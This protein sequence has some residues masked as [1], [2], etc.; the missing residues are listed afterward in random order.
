M[1]GL[2]DTQQIKADLEEKGYAI[3]SDVLNTQEITDYINDYRKWRR[4]NKLLRFHMKKDPHGIHKFHQIGHQR[5]VWKVRLNKNVQAVFKLIW[6]TDD[7]VVSF[8]GCCYIPKN[9]TK[10]DTLWT[11]SD[12]NGRE[13]KRICY[14]GFV[15]MT[16]NEERTLV[17]YEGSH[18]LH[19]KYMQDNGLTGS[20]HWNRID[21]DYLESIQDTKRA[22]KVNAGDLVIWDSRV[23]HQNRYGKPMSEKRLVQYISFL[24]KNN[25][26]NTNKMH[27]KRVKYFRE[28]RT[29]SHW[30]YPIRVN[31]LQPRLFKGEDEF[32]IDYSKLKTIKLDDLEDDIMAIL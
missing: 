7:L 11:H 1:P 22:L 31:G 29:T 32:K 6:D 27:D 8:D 13:D 4:E 23:F 21:A 16:S 26:A 10:P 5:F 28:R 2:M 15:A 9:C 19:Y 20:A 17:V 30:A 3:V 25:P 12:Q 24:P 14:Q 18:K